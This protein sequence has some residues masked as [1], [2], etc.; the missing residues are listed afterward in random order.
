MTGSTT[1]LITYGWAALFYSGTP[2]VFHIYISS[3]MLI[4]S[5]DSENSMLVFTM[6]IILAFGIEHK[7]NDVW[8]MN[9]TASTLKVKRAKANENCQP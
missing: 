4:E 6:Q 5:Y 8:L 3:L 9:T 7:L 2:L 1:T